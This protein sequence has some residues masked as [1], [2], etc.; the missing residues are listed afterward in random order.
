MSEPAPDPHPDSPP[1]APVVPHQPHD[2]R[3]RLL[4]LAA[5]LVR[6]QNARLLA[7]YMRLRRD[8]R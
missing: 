7:E 8:G 2:P 4:E 1:P 3:R 5:S 6:V